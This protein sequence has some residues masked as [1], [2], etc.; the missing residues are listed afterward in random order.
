VF[1]KCA[2]LA[3]ETTEREPVK[4]IPLQAGI[5][6]FFDYLDLNSFVVNAASESKFLFSHAASQSLAFNPN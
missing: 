2:Y 4:W 1:K 5:D 6:A 3:E